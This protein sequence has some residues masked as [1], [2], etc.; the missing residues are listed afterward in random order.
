MPH[1]AAFK[2]TPVKLSPPLAWR[3]E[4]VAAGQPARW[5]RSDSR[6]QIERR[7][8]LLAAPFTLVPLAGFD[9]GGIA[10]PFVTLQAA[11]AATLWP[12][13]RLLERMRGEFEIEV[14]MRRDAFLRGTQ[15]L[16][17]ALHGEALADEPRRSR[18]VQLRAA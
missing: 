17:A 12:R 8:R 5:L 1:V 4:P 3:K 9:G 7:D 15:A 13:E 18:S 14:A 6:W 16:I 2:E 10:L 11:Q